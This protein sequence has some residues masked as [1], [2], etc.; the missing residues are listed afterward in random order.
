MTY[1]IA[2]LIHGSNYNSVW[3]FIYYTLENCIDTTI[4]ERVERQLHLQT[5]DDI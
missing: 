2:N 5:G 1:S 4:S 3:F